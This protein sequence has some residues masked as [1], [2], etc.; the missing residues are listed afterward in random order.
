MNRN[1]EISKLVTEN[2]NWQE[3]TFISYIG[4]V[5]S[6]LNC[7]TPLELVALYEKAPNA[8]ELEYGVIKSRQLNKPFYLRVKELDIDIAQRKFTIVKEVILDYVV[9]G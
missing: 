6:L 9:N 2:F 5:E 1:L 4:T 7:K 8:F 3:L